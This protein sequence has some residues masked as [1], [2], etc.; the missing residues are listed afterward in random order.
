[1]DVDI[2]PFLLFLS[3]VLGVFVFYRLIVSRFFRIWEGL[4]TKAK[5]DISSSS[6]DSDAI[7]C[8]DNDYTKAEDL[9]L[10][11]YV[12]KSSY[13]S[14]YNGT[15]VTADTLEQRLADG[16]RFIDLNVFSASGGI[17]Y[18]GFSRDNAPTMIQKTLMFSDALKTIHTY[19]FTKRVKPGT[20]N[21]S[22]DYLSTPLFLNL[23]VYRPV[24]SNEDIVDEIGKALD[25]ENNPNYHKTASGEAALVNGC[26]SLGSIGKKIVIS[27]DIEN[28]I[29]IYAPAEKPIA[30]EIP[31]PT[32]K[33]LKQFVGIYTG[34]NTWRAS[35][36]Y[37]DPSITAK[38]KDLKISD[39]TRSPYK[40]N[41]ATMRIAYPHPEDQSNPDFTR[42]ILHNSI[43]NVPF[44]V[45]IG[46]GELPKYEKMFAELK[47]SYVPMAYAY[48]YLRGL[49][50]R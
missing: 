42:L 17:L 3:V 47:T 29:Q 12:I 30:T 44:R 5:Q 4:E 36:Q 48:T 27:M 13:N 6:D 10:K 9:P 45:Y 8:A 32:Q 16:Y 50:N 38:T 35:Y 7:V 26:T 11:E 14:A 23:R 49:A 34:G 28:L 33:R 2:K 31:E 21:V 20:V 46:G 19:A 25:W 43:Q 22:Y 1:M 15:D 18:V 41:V 40:T 39:Q 24:D 37:T